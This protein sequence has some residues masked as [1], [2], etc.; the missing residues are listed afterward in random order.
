[1]F[2]VPE[3]NQH[4]IRSSLPT[5]HGFSPLPKEGGVEIVNPLMVSASPKSKFVMLFQFVATIDVSSY[6]CIV[7]ALRF[8][9]E[10]C[11]GEQKIMQHCVDISNEAGRQAAGI[12]GTEVM[13]NAEKTLTRCSMTNFTLPLKI[14][15]AKGEIP[16][17]DA[18]LVASWIT[19]VLAKEYDI[20]CPAFVHAGKF[21][22]R[23][24]GQIYLE[25]ED[26]AMGAEA[27]SNLCGRAA[28]GE[29]SHSESA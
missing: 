17:K 13:E 11:G 10:V 8:R 25:M 2:Y 3:R 12:L 21:W 15:D 23:F 16:S 28:K 4:L 19:A 24:S 18:Y 5:S 9:K 22:T 7:E 27:L 29:Y 14:G 1:M 20:Y 26:Y 6:L